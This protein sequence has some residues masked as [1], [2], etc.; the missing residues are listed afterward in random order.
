MNDSS[1]VSST[2]NAVSDLNTA[3]GLSTVSGWKV[4]VSM[5]ALAIVATSILWVYW[6]MHLMPFM[7]LQEKLAAAFENSSPRVD[8][9]QRK[10]HKGTPMTLRVVMRAPFDPTSTDPLVLEQI[11]ERLNKTQRLAAETLPLDT[12][13]L[14]EV[15]LFHENKEQA[16][17]QKTF[18]KDLK[19]SANGQ[20]QPPA[21]PAVDDAE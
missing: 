19:T 17:Q 21:T 4:V 20:A 5:F 11:E 15:H 1:E 10:I 14:L 3:G 13:E 9:G 18:L 16:L 8:G 12:F 7:P 6:D 2:A